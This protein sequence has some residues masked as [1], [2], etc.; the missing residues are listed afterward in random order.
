MDTNNQL[1]IWFLTGS[2]HLYGQETLLKVSEN[3]QQI[4]HFL[5]DNIPVQLKFKPVLKSSEEIYQLIL[6][7]NYQTNCI[8]IITW[9][10]TFSPAKMWI[11]GLKLLQ[12]PLCHL[13]T[14]FNRDIPWQDIDMDF[15]NLN[16]SAHGDREFGYILSRMKIPRKV[17]AGHWKNE[18]ISSQLKEWSRA[19]LGWHDLQNAR[20][21]RFGDNMRHVAVTEG[22]KVEAQLTFG[23]Q[24]NTHGVGDLVSE[25]EKVSESDIDDLCEVYNNE[26]QLTT[27]LSKKGEYYQSLRAAAKIELGLTDFLTKGNY[28]G[29]TTTFEDL[30]G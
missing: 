5:N 20:F 30:H 24:V 27:S 11:N 21:V 15:M 8:G 7:A 10:H 13:H 26:Y 18:R 19:I 22:D 1:E 14:Q 29:F 25:I 12:K 6:S 28:K 16:Q 3:A 17:I 9:M 4:V 2:Q 23:F